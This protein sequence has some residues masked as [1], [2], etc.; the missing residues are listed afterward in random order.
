MITA[1]I[2]DL[3]NISVQHL[4]RRR[5]WLLPLF[6]NML[7][8]GRSSVL[9]THFSSCLCVYSLA[10]ISMCNCLVCVFMRA[11]YIVV[12]KTVVRGVSHPQLSRPPY[13]DHLR[14]GGSGAQPLIDPNGGGQ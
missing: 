12:R 2:K 10:Y 13:L 5:L 1:G 14:E 8:S 7:N 9:S 11:A 6:L 3:L 4:G